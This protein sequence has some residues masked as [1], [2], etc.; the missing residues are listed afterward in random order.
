MVRILF[1][2]ARLAYQADPGTYIRC[3]WGNILLEKAVAGLKP[4]LRAGEE[5]LE[6]EDAIKREAFLKSF[7]SRLFDELTPPEA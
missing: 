7:G 6:E 4:E 5:V 3:G 1:A 2:A